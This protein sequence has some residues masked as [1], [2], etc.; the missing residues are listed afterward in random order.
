M[1][2]Q[3]IIAEQARIAALLTDDRVDELV[4]AQGQYQIGDIFL[5]TVENV[6]PGIDAAFINIGESEKNGFIHVSD[7]GPLRLK[8]GTF[9]ITELLEPK[10]KVLVQ[11]IKE[12]T[13]SKGPRLTGSISIP[14]KY[15][16]LQPYGQGVNISRKINTETE[17]S[18]LK[19]LGVLIK[20]PST[21]LLFRTEAEKIKEELL[22]E[23]LEQLTKQWENIIKVSEASN[24]PNLIKRDD[25]FS[26]KILRDYIKE[27]TKSIIIDSKFSVASAKDFLINYESDIEIQFH[28]NSLNQHIFEKYEIKKTIQKA[29]QPRVDL[30][31]GGY[32][33]IEPTEALTVID[34][35]SGSFTRSA[36]SRQTVLWTNCEAAVE[37]SRQMKLRNIGGVIVIDFI[38]MESRRDQF[39]LLEHFTSAIKDDSARPQIAQLTELGLV[40]LTRKRQGQNIYELFGKK[41]STCDGTGHVENI[42]NHEISNFKIKNIENESNQSN[43]IKAIDTYQSIDEQE[44][45]IDKELINTKDLSKENSSNKKEKENENDNLNQSNSKEKNIITVDL[46]NEE[47][48]VFSQL[49]INPLIK[50]GKEYLTSNNFVRLKESNKETEK[51]LDNKKTKTKQIKKISKSGEDKIQIKIEANANS[52]DKSTNENNEVVFIDKKDEI[53]LTDE[54][55]NARK[56]RRRSSASIE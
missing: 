40:E 12:P 42:L 45:I 53:E 5:G 20:P 43:I 29:L 28:D 9:G 47:K 24:P 18:R 27:S 34:V 56:K 3:I 8:K 11:V 6:L 39:Q 15:L 2:Q 31:S 46:T 33:I 37:I 10:Q 4:V 26:L 49:G 14:G 1:S 25:D 55:N 38:D 50:L 23:D 35:N 7:L 44:K 41:C 22:I 16:I 48:I 52:K 51:P 30:P 32:I 17:R 21:G 13:G 36:N 54:L 19:A